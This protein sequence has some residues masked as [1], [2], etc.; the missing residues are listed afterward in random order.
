MFLRK[1]SEE[2]KNVEKNNLIFIDRWI[3]NE[4]KNANT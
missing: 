3:E 2:L 1:N 4:Q